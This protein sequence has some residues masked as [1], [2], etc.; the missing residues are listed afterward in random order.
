MEQQLS[1]EKIPDLSFAHLAPEVWESLGKI[2]RTGWV[3]RGVENPETVQEHTI[4]LRELAWSF[5]LEEEVKKGLI[6]MLEAHD[7]P[8]AIEGDQVIVTSDQEEKRRLKLEKFKKEKKALE[9]I[10]APMGS[11]GEK[12]MALWLRFEESDDKIATF[13][14]ELDKYQAIEKSLQYEKEQRILCFKE[15]FDYNGPNITDR[16]LLKKL[17]ELKEEWDSFQS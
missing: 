5:G 11:I 9:E 4:A 15:F 7:W 6:E 10:C 2:K 16:I 1:N 13:A 12:I 17:S 14:R 8:E 3:K